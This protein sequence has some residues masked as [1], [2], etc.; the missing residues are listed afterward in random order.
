MYQHHSIQLS[1]CNLM[2]SISCRG[3]K[4]LIVHDSNW[5]LDIV[6]ID[7]SDVIQVLFVHIEL[8]SDTQKQWKDEQIHLNSIWNLH[9]LQIN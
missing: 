6:G 3:M 9:T 8:H 5:I 2:Q 7:D 4:H 1:T